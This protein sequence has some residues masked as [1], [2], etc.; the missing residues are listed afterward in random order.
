[1]N[2]KSPTPLPAAASAPIRLSEFLPYQISLLADHIARR[3]TRIARRHGEL[4]LSQWRVLAAVAEAPGRTAN[5]VVDVT[6]MDKGIVSRA[7]RSLIDMSL[8]ERRASQT[9]GRMAHLHLTAAGMSRYMDIARDV[10]SVDT[11]IRQALSADEVCALGEA[12]RAIN[13]AL[14]GRDDQGER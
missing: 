13:E 11:M 14:A 10:R 7:V 9:D 5:E 3:T 12:V 6:P 1:M 8:L 2:V 4:N